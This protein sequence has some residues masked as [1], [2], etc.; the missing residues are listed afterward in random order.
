MFECLVRPTRIL[1]VGTAAVRDAVSLS[2]SVGV[3][4]M[5]MPLAGATMAMALAP[6]VLDRLGPLGQA[7]ADAT[8]RTERIA[9]TASRMGEQAAAAA[10]DVVRQGLSA[11]GT[12]GRQIVPSSRA[13]LDLRPQ[14]ARRRVWVGHGHAHIEVRGMTGTGSEHRRLRDGVTRRLT[15][16]KGVRWAEVNGVTG[17]VLV[18]FDEGRVDVA[19]LL[20]TV[21]GVEE[22]QGTREENFPWS[23]PVHPADPTPVA[24]AGVELA[25]DGLAV[26]TAVV[27]RALRLPEMPRGVRVAQAL[28]ELERPLRR[29]LKRRIGP[30]GTDVLLALTAA[31]VHGLSQGPGTPAMD[32]LY[33]LELLAEA[34]S[35]RAVWDRREGDLCCAAWAV[36]SE[37]PERPRRPVPRPKGPIEV[38]VDRLGP[39]ALLGAGAVLGLTRDP[40]RAADAILVAV[41][42]AARRGREGF[43]TTVGRE[44]A[45]RGVVPL[46]AAAWRRL[47]RVSAIVIDSPLLCTDRTQILAAEPAADGDMAA[48]WRDAGRVLEGRSWEDLSG[49]G[50]WERD[51]LRLER[52]A[53]PDEPGAVRLILRCG[54]DL[55]ARLTVGAQL[56]PLAD[57]LIDAAVCTGARVLLT[58]HASVADLVPRVDE[59]LPQ[60]RPLAVSVQRL[61]EEGHGV[62]VVSET[63]DQALAVADVGV[64]VLGGPACLC[65]SADVLC[66]PGLEDVWRI[67]R[68]VAAARPVSER[69]VQ[70]A[71]A[72]SALGALFALVGDRRSGRGRAMQPVYGAALVAL[73]HGTIAGLAATRQRAPVA[74]THVP[75]HALDALEVLARLDATR[76]ET[77]HEPTP[78]WLPNAVTGVRDLGRRIPGSSRLAGLAGPTRA[79][80]RFVGA[81]REELQDPLTPVLAVGAAA[82]AIVGS[83]VDALLVAAVM[84]GNALISGTQ[85]VRAENALRRLFLEQEVVARR[86]RRSRRGDAPAETVADLHAV[87]LER[88]RAKGLSPG[89]I[90]A[91]RASD[92][93]PA[94]ARLLSAVDLEVDEST[95]TGESMPAEKTVQPTPGAPLAERRCMVF[96]GTTVLAG[97][98]YAVVVATEHATEAGRAARSAGRAAT[99]GGLQAHLAEVT[100]TALPITGI[101]GA[102]VTG[103]AL[104]RGLPLREAVAAGV[105]VA[106]AAVPEGL[107]LVATVAQAAS[108]RRLSRRGVLVRSSRTLEALGRVDVVCFDKTG[109]LTQ[110]RLAV[111]RLASPHSDV[112]TQE[113][114]AGR[115]LITAARACPPVDADDVHT[116]PHATD[117]A[118]LEAAERRTATDHREDWRLLA[119]LPFE[120]NRGYAAALGEADGGP[121][122][123]VKGA[124]EV[125]LPRC[126]TVTRHAAAGDD[127]T[128]DLTEQ[129]GQSAQRTVQRMAADGLRVLAV[130][131]RR[132]GLRGGADLT[133]ETVADLT[134]LGL[135]G[136]ADTPRADAADALR[137]LTED[138]TRL[139]MITGDHP[140]TATAV[141]RMVGMPADTVLTGAELD[142]MPYRERVR[143]V[144]DTSV[145]A[146]VSPEQK[147]RIVEALQAA[148]HVVAMTGDGTNDAAAIRLADVGIGVAATESSAARSAADLVLADV[149]VGHIHE[150][151]LEGRE[152]WHRVREAVSILVGGNAGE[153]AFMVLGTALAGRAPMG[154]RQMLLVNMLTD[155]FPALAVAVA[156]GDEQHRNGEPPSP[157]LGAALARA[158]ANRGTAT[159][160][161]AALAWTIGRY[162]GRER[163][164]SSMGLA[165]LIG[166]QLAQ[167]LLTGWRSPL[168]VATT[169]ASATVLVAVVELPGISQFFG[170][171]PIGPVAWSV[172]VVSAA[173]GTLL[174]ALGPRLIGAPAETRDAVEPDTAVGLDGHEAVA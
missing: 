56:A 27:A 67:L 46:N 68:A 14:R 5:R 58:P 111:A 166:T 143:R 132:D 31:A 81:V 104:L 38:W 125:V 172:V 142:R 70:Y 15:R 121:L 20:D 8:E 130:A 55:Q 161:G 22:A 129:H 99:P 23:R 140:T 107:P 108:A 85:R 158:V 53:G 73:L 126:T 82:S 122:L 16:L 118:V 17:Q 162:T 32:G 144:A 19:T 59:I 88:V 100:R 1:G 153:V 152:L 147:L 94:D 159:A 84:S 109:T 75:W 155:M 110:G 98:A 9:S 41:P 148:G 89:D 74:V 12:I 93:V 3:A 60:D 120:T 117:R 138:G 25:A 54:A 21:R 123:V 171:T 149:D 92:V 42:K 169:L 165:A 6:E 163:R 57:A 26:A 63:D 80:V 157:A 160:V 87:P 113:P 65:W 37:A 137:R 40:G 30:I 124:P 34:M 127:D 35:R 114:Y 156:T 2:T 7:V 135:I 64:A 119:E 11:A 33:R 36:P 78:G 134:L 101:G 29:Q 170:C 141:A 154:V 49:P 150:A 174:A 13:L 136:I 4:A 76:T 167:T 71:Q 112:D 90:I 51:G 106:V 97:T 72:G 116:V 168:V 151:L 77:D 128:E 24:A 61:E 103:L 69:A 39:G 146:R 44:L 96:E 43:A 115:L 10:A 133:E 52:E 83:G 139:I 131:E 86:L 105:S 145:F 18:A 91:L 47:D 48:V 62:L 164:A 28:L 45:R 66:G 95:L 173:A 79:T 102:A 50:P